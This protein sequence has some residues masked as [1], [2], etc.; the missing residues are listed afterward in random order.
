MV[1]FSGEYLRLIASPTQSTN[2]E[3]WWGVLGLGQGFLPV[4]GRGVVGCRG[5]AGIVPG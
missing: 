5:A 2:L 4:L 3:L 1:E